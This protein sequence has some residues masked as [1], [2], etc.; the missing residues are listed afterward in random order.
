MPMGF[1][2]Q[3]RAAQETQRKQAERI[4]NLEQEN[5]M[6]KSFKDSIN[7]TLARIEAL[8]QQNAYLAARRREAVSQ[9]HNLR[10]LHQEADN[11]FQMRT[12]DMQPDDLEGMLC[13]Y[14]TMVSTAMNLHQRTLGQMRVNGQLQHYMAPLPRPQYPPMPVQYHHAYPPAYSPAGYCYA[15]RM[16]YCCRICSNTRDVHSYECTAITA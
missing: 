15:H 3:L 16:P 14:G 8:E 1:A 10:T 2:A 6:L 5:A 4:T 13:A 7:N 9:L 12:V 11:A